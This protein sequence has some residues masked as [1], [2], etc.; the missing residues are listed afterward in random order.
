MRFS[1]SFKAL[2]K[3][4]KEVLRGTPPELSA[5][6]MQGNGPVLVALRSCV[7]WIVCLQKR[8]VFQRLWRIILSCV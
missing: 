3:A 8:Q 5:D 4:I 1:M 7:T 2:L 6:V